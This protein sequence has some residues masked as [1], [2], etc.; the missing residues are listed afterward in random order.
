MLWCNA[1]SATESNAS[2]SKHK[3][4]ADEPPPSKRQQIEDE[5][6]TVVKDLQEKHADKYT[7]PQFRGWARMIT[8]GKHQDRDNIPV[9]LDLD[10]QPKK[11]K[12]PTLQ[13]LSLMLPRHLLKLQRV[14]V[15][16]NVFLSLWSSLLVVHPLHLQLHA[17]Y[18]IFQ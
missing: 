1:K 17:V 16:V 2:G 18:M 8:S 10:N 14:L 4:M 6:D 11:Q 15:S 3:K 12:R 7:L 13:K 9:F 5:L